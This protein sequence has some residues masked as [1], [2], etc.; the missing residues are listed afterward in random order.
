MTGALAAPS[1]PEVQPGVPTV[2]H[3]IA[4][5][6]KVNL[7]LAENLL[8]IAQSLVFIWR[9]SAAFAVQMLARRSHKLNATTR[10]LR[11]LFRWPISSY[12][13]NF[14]YDADPNRNGGDYFQ[15]AGNRPA[16]QT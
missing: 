3:P 13:R 6:A 11:R 10:K 2:A 4:I 16:M 14:V 9:S 5:I 15:F 7:G 12:R 1:E 8:G